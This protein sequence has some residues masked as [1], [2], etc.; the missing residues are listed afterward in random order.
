MRQLNF[1]AELHP[2]TLRREINRMYH[3]HSRELMRVQLKVMM[4][5]AMGEVVAEQLQALLREAAQRYRRARKKAKGCL[6]DEFVALTGYNRCYAARALRHEV[7]GGDR[8]VPRLII[9][10][11]GRV[12]GSRCTSASRKCSD[13]AGGSSS[14]RRRKRAF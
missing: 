8:P 9:A 13:T 7:R 4:E 5:E 1:A 11:G 6:L 14:C 12:I 10:P 3:L 2:T